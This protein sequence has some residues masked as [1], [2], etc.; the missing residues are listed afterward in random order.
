MLR[1][2]VE[3][4]EVQRPVGVAPARCALE[5]L[6]RLGQLPPLG[7]QRPEVGGRRDMAAGVGPRVCLLGLLTAALLLQQRP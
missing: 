3:R 4:G 1:R 5:R 7:Q 6:S 2:H